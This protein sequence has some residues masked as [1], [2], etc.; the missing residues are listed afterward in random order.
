V[1]LAVR[2]HQPVALDYGVSFERLHQLERKGATNVRPAWKSVR[3]APA[4]EG[5]F[6][7]LADNDCNVS[8]ARRV[9]DATCMCNPN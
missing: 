4:D 7:T 6:R 5:H 1:V 3:A 2:D 8:V 9:V